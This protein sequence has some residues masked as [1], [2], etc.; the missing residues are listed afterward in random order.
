VIVVLVSFALAHS[1][2][3][4]SCR[5][6]PLALLPSLSRAADCLFSLVL[7]LAFSQS[8]PF[9]VRTV[10]LRPRYRSYL[11]SCRCCRCFLVVVSYG[12]AG[13]QACEAG[14]ADIQAVVRL[15]WHR[16]VLFVSFRSPLFFPVFYCIMLLVSIALASWSF[17][18]V[19]SVCSV[20]LVV[21]VR[22]S[23]QLKTMS[24][25]FSLG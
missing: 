21:F 9:L 10:L 4:I 3:H 23:F 25:Y 17:C 7:A 6:F 12:G 2:A 18:S 22:D 24:W 16:C 19:D 15:R 11:R 20:L 14:W 1:L 8:L 13:R 5:L